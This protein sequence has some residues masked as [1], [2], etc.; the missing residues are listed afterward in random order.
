MYFY[1]KVFLGYL[2]RILEAHP[3]IIIW[4]DSPGPSSTQSPPQTLQNTSYVILCLAELYA[5]HSWKWKLFLYD[6]LF[7]VWPIKQYGH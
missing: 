2:F 6:G 1:I 5:D 7:I 3:V 4:S